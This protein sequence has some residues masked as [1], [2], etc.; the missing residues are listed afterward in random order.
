MQDFT[1]VLF[2]VELPQESGKNMKFLLVA[3]AVMGGAFLMGICRNIF[4]SLFGLGI[5]L[6]IALAGSGVVIFCI[7]TPINHPG[8]SGVLWLFVI[9]ALAISLALWWVFISAI[10]IAAVRRG[11]I[12]NDKEESV[13]GEK[14]DPDK[15][16]GY[17]V[18]F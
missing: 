15:P 13:S 3:C 14:L 12:D 18:N 2:Q 8:D 16:D 7:V 5:L 1:G 17:N 9:P 10:T 6:I 11:V 4:V